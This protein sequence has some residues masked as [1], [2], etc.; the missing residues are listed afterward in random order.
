MAA[1]ASEL[2][3]QMLELVVGMLEWAARASELVAR[4]FQWAA[5]AVLAAWVV[6]S[7]LSSPL[8]WLCLYYMVL[9]ENASVFRFVQ[10]AQ[11]QGECILTNYL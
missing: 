8:N 5:K 7:L 1:E 3:V 4:A 2:A 11:N 6:G 9:L 10:V